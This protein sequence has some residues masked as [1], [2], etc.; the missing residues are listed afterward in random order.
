MGNE[1]EQVC[2][3]GDVGP[4]RMRRLVALARYLNI[5]ASPYMNP[6]EL[7]GRI[8]KQLAQAPPTPA[9]I[10]TLPREM[11]EEIEL[12]LPTR[13]VQAMRA[14]TS[15]MRST[16]PA[17]RQWL[18]KYNN[19]LVAVGL[20]PEQYPRGSL[21][22]RQLY[23]LFDDL[24][25][26]SAF[27][28]LLSRYGD[29]FWLPGQARQ[30]QARVPTG[31]FL[32]SFIPGQQSAMYPDPHMALFHD[33]AR[34]ST[35][36]TQKEGEEE[37]LI[38]L[39]ATRFPTPVESSAS[40]V[41]F[42][43]IIRLTIN[44]QGEI[45]NISEFPAACTPGREDVLLFLL[46]NQDPVARLRAA[47]QN[48]APGEYSQMLEQINPTAYQQGYYL[49]DPA[50][51]TIELGDRLSLETRQR[52]MNYF[53]RWTSNGFVLSISPTVTDYLPGLTCFSK[54]T[55]AHAFIQA[56]KDLK[57]F[58]WAML[59]TPEKQNIL[60]SMLPIAHAGADR[61]K[62]VPHEF[63][64]N[65]D[66]LYTLALGVLYINNIQQ[67]PYRSQEDMFRV[68]RDS[69]STPDESENNNYRSRH[70]TSK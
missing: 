49:P 58:R 6:T 2:V 53:A 38:T 67:S 13:L 7:C 54:A 15:Q 45:I 50:P 59:S 57:L 60:E 14:T 1:Y 66:D 39:L 44:D 65:R 69:L 37:A 46:Q 28:Y 61:W 47:L 26:R 27:E 30:S 22:Q 35:R 4:D 25:T 29:F 21:E 19:Q 33:I 8:R 36:I 9:A 31:G 64:Q 3:T 68:I 56:V 55:V 10:A 51:R 32:Y 43:V 48:F 70:V 34:E 18:N 17:T 16:A 41:P 52:F 24:S 5:A 23:S 40:Q 63:P 20:A 12:H 62:D 11:I 42:N